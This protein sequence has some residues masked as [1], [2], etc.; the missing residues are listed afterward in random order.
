VASHELNILGS[1]LVHAPTFRDDVANELM[2]FIVYG[3]L[4]LWSPV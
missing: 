4:V 3:L 1:E 2:T